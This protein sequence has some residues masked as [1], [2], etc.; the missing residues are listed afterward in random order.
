MSQQSIHPL[1]GRR[2]LRSYLA[3]LILVALIPTMAA[4]GLA[5]WRAGV[6]FR[7]ASTTRLQD[8]AR[9]LARAVEGELEHTTAMLGVL[10][11]VAPGAGGSRTSMAEGLSRSRL[12]STSV[13]LEGRIVIQDRV[14]REDGE[15]H[16]GDELA[17]RAAATRQPAVSNLFTAQ[18]EGRPQIAIAVPQARADGSTRVATLTIAPEKLVRSLQQRE[19]G[20]SGILVAVTDGT[21]HLVARSLDPERHIGQPVPDWARLK[22]VGADAGTFRGESKEGTPIVLAFQELHGTPGWVVVVGEPSVAFDARW[23][24]PLIELAL[25]GG[26][27]I[28]LALAAIAWISRLVLRPVQALARRAGAVA[29]GAKPRA[30]ETIPPSPIAEFEALRQSIEAAETALRARAEAERQMAGVLA[31]SERRYRTLAEFGALVFWRWDPSGAMVSAGGWA[32]LTGQPEAAAFGR[33]WMNSIHPADRPLVTAAIDEVRPALAPLDAEFR[34]ATGTGQWRWVRARG[35]PILDESGAVTEWVGVFE[36]V[37]ARRQA[38]A[39]IAHMAHHDALTGLPNRLLFRERLEQAVARAGRGQPEAVLCIDLDRFKEINDTLGHPVGDALL[40]TVAQRIQAATRE[41]DTVAR[42]GGDEFAIAQTGVPQPVGASALAERLIDALSQ[43]YELLGHQLV[44]G[45]SVGIA[46][47]GRTD[48]PDRVLKSADIALY[49]AKEEGRGRFFFF[50]PAMDARM[51]QRRMMEM[52]LRRALAENEFELHYQPLVK[53]E[54]REFSGFEALL[55]WNHPTRGMLHPAEF[56]PLAEETGQ[57]VPLGEWVLKQA[58]ADAT[59]W[60]DRI[61][62]AVNVSPVQLAHRGLSD[63]VTQAL[64]SSGLAPSR[65]DIEITEN[66]LLANIEA[67]SATLFKLKSMGVKITMDDFGTGCSSLGYLRSFPF[68]KI[69]IDAS[70]VRS[71]GEEEESRAIIRAVTGLCETLG[72]ATTAEGV[73]TE[74]QLEFLTA[75]HCT[76]VQGFLF[77]EPCPAS[78]VPA[79]LAPGPAQ[80]RRRLRVVT[81]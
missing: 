26:V 13:P 39:R 38:Q 46:V 45:A 15:G 1:G 78:D 9:T 50:E 67:A 65:L 55:R 68:D 18:P 29:Q 4:A 34:V 52:S 28:L 30:E 32:E 20:L 66:A 16:E 63:A 80:R 61:K 27:A 69:K 44:I 33:G 81:N 10:A 79:L 73:E 17:D 60:P 21:G 7:E 64:Q 54:S 36:D 8:T 25:G 56:I 71:L 12:N 49:R 57:I 23:Q 75:E 41:G 53:A 58:C 11:N 2:P 48:D 19:S 24:E 70:F 5:V 40:C 22:A 62:V 14:G 6:A 72:I 43:P 74:A 31:T 35:A 47:I 51:Q 37:D 77:S 59:K 42:L 3:A 76:E